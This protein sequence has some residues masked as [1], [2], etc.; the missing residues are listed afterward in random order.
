MHRLRGSHEKVNDFNIAESPNKRPFNG[1]LTRR[2]LVR[3][4]A[5][6][7]QFIRYLL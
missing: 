3:K 7:G 2:K 4:H 5:L 1:I 6:H